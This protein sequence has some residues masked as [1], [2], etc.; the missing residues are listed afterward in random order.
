M[1]PVKTGF[2]ELL[3]NV[4]GDSFTSVSLF[5]TNIFLLNEVKNVFGI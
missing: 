5:D 1:S 4:V 3:D 2:R